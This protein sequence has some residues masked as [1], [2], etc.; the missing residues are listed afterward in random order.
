MLQ[1]VH[2]FVVCFFKF[3]VLHHQ[4]QAKIEHSESIYSH[5]IPNKLPSRHANPATAGDL[6]SHPNG[7]YMKSHVIAALET[8]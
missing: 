6:N 4:I 1:T 7:I 2:V 8:T 3:K 5:S